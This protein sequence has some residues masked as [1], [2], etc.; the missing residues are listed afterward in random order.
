MEGKKKFSLTSAILSVICVVFVAEAAAPV[1]AIGNSQFFWWIFLLIAFLLP[2]GLISSELG[3]TYIGEGGI[4]DWVTKAYG[5]RWGA[6]VSW[7]YWINYPLWLASLA[8]MTPELLTT[9]TGIKFS[10]PMMIIVELIFTW[11]VVWISFYPVSDSIWIL[12]GAAVI[13]MV[14]AVLIGGLGLYVALTKGVANEFTLKSMLP[15]FD[16]RSLSFISVIIFNLL[17]FEVIC[18]FADD[19]ENPKK[20][21]PQA[22]VAAGLV[23]AA[24]YIFSAFGIGVAIPTDQISTGSGMMDSFKLLTGSTEGWFIMLMAFLFLLTLFGNMI[25]WSLGV[26]NTACYAAENDDMPKFFEKRS[27]KN[28]MPIGAALMNG[29]VASV[30]IVLAPILPNQDLFWA[31]FSLNVVLF[32]LS[33]IPVFP[34]FYKLRKIDPD[35]PRPFK[36]NGKPGFLKVLV[37]LPMIMIII[38]LIFT[39]VPLDFSPAA[40]NE[41]LPITIGAIIFIL[42]GEVIIYVKKIKKGTKENG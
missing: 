9:I 20:Q 3:T 18:T 27:K 13:K 4:Y 12:N 41:K 30:V 7:Y 5:H 24:I 33:Y 21:I 25:S 6:R 15:T 16:L 10:T 8:V 1:A 42:F 19:M 39:A 38:S 32:L 29:I 14:L 22:I 17:G 36:V 40:L 2:Y 28:D 31:F 34:A 37:V 23:I 35:T 11:I 26:N